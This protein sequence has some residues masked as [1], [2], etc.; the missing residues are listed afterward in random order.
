MPKY[1]DYHKKLPPLP[2]EAVKMMKDKLGSKKADQFGVVALSSFIT[3]DSQGWCVTEAP[4]ADAVCKSHDPRGLKLSKGD[5][6]ELM[7]SL[8]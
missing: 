2:P 6:H 8:P 7:M 3:K 4:N 5:V 1:I